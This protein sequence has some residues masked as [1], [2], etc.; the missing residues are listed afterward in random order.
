MACNRH[1][2]AHC[3]CLHWYKQADWFKEEKQPT[4]G[5]V[6]Q[7]VTTCTWSGMA[8]SYHYTAYPACVLHAVQQQQLMHMHVVM[9][10]LTEWNAVYAGRLQTAISAAF[11][12]L[13]V[14]AGLHVYILVAS[15]DQ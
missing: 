14:P 1:C 12:K 9:H 2:I 10:S 13:L 6:L 15:L 8:M 5:E 3:G 7:I 4:E 11:P